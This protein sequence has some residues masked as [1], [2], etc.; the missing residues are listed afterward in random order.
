[1]NDQSRWLEGQARGQQGGC[2]ARPGASG[3]GG[4]LTIVTEER[5]QAQTEFAPQRRL[6]LAWPHS[7][8]AAP[9]PDP[10]TTWTGLYAFRIKGVE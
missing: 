5:Y 9:W 10:P 2:G 6:L 7:H 8:L 4:L 3:A 1:M